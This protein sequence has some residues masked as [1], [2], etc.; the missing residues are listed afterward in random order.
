[1]LQK[2]WE[3]YDDP[4]TIM[5]HKRIALLVLGLAGS[6]L[7]ATMLHTSVA[8]AIAIGDRQ[9]VSS[10]DSGGFVP[11]E[12]F[13]PRCVKGTTLTLVTLSSYDGPYLEDGTDREVFGISALQVINTGE[14][15]ISRCQITLYYEGTSL[16]FDGE[17]IPPGAPVVLLERNAKTFMKADVTGC[18]GWQ[19]IMPNASDAC[20]Y[21][22]INDRAMGTLVVTNTSNFTLRNI[23][24]HYKNWLSPPGYFVGGIAYTVSIHEL[25]PGQ[26]QLLYP[27]HYAKGYSR[28]V[29]VSAEQ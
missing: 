18:S 14:H 29:S 15:V 21:V 8:N 7:A 6:F 4:Q 28:V 9:P 19:T 24:V 23:E 13:F 5:T 17:Q 12:R 27:Y 22:S 11:S 20:K 26:T 16:S 10:T 25:K 1:M 3:G 2:G